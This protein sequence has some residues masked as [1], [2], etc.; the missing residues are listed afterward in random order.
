MTPERMDID[1]IAEVVPGPIG[2]VEIRAVSRASLGELAPNSLF[3]LLWEHGALTVTGF[4]DQLKDFPNL[5][6]RLIETEEGSTASDELVGPVNP[7]RFALPFHSELSATPFRPDVIMFCCSKA[8]DR[9]GATTVCDGLE[10]FEELP[11]TLKSRFLGSALTYRVQVPPRMA[12][13]LRV[14]PDLAGV[15][16]LHFSPDGSCTLDWITRAVNEGRRFRGRV[17][18]CNSILPFAPMKCV[19]IGDELVDD[20]LLATIHPSLL[21]AT[22]RVYW[23]AGDVVILDNC[24][25]MHGRDSFT[26]DRSILSAGGRAK[27]CWPE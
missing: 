24:R 10:V 2:G 8:A 6:A 4:V 20:A 15:R 7:G 11:D 21:R 26:G 25:M 12:Q 13:R 1:R 17:A 27:G 18:F 22:R 23:H 5:A 3:N 19:W 9:D 14:K 16:N